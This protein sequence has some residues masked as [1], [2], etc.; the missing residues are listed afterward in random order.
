MILHIAKRAEWD[1]AQRRN[2]YAPPSLSAE[3]FIHCS[4]AAQILD[5]ANRFFHGQSDLV[6]LCIDPHRLA[7][8]LRYEAPAMAHDEGRA[9]RFPH[10]YGP[11][12]LEAVT[13]VLDFPCERTAPSACPRQ[14]PWL[15][16]D[17]SA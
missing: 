12:N 14:C 8:P 11:L 4:T 6:V 5:T 10:L 3:G 16:A 1:E 13:Q 15:C 2:E 9:G 17:R 7:A